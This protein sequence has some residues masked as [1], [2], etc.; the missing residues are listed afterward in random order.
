M[1][2]SELD[3]DFD[4]DITAKWMA[5]YISEKIESIE[6]TPDSEK[7]KEA[8][9]TAILNLWGRRYCLP[10]KMRPFERFEPILNGLSR[11]D[12]ESQTPFVR[13]LSPFWDENLD[14]I[15]DQ[16]KSWIDLA[17]EVDQGARVVVNELLS[18]AS[19]G[20]VTD[21]TKGLI[22]SVV[23]DHS[24]D[25]EVIIRLTRARHEGD[26]GLHNA[27]VLSRI[28]KVKAMK[29]SCDLIV[30]RLE[31]QLSDQV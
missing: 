29:K 16:A 28:E 2:I 7:A 31:G 12:E 3:L 23:G 25:V 24:L 13:V 21:K 20:A 10:E 26:S 9:F 19:E 1:I 30:E 8:C 6:K 4:N 5:H 15:D 22:D 17:L 14:G 11:L 27:E 18:I